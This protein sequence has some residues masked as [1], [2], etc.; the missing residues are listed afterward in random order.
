MKQYKISYILTTF[1]KLPYLKITLPWWVNNIQQG[2]QL[3]I[4][5]GNSTD[6]SIEFIKETIKNHSDILFISEK[7]CGE[8]H[9]LNKGILLSEGNYI[10]TISADDVYNL[11]AIRKATDWME[12]HNEI[13][14]MGSNGLSISLI[15]SNKIQFNPQ[16][17]EVYFNEYKK[18]HKPF[19]LSG[20]SYLIRKTSVSK[21]GL[22]NTHY[23]M[24]DFEYSL[25]G[26]SNPCIS[27][28]LCTT[29][30]Y[31]YIVTPSS[32]SI[33]MHRRMIEEHVKWNTFYFGSSIKIQLWKIKFLISQYIHQFYFHKKKN[34]NLSSMNYEEVFH[35]A[36]QYLQ[37]YNQKEL[38]ILT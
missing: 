30:F 17:Q 38:E 8:A 24:V 28:A 21:L 37:K 22:F 32:N 11:P 16:N 36:L 26:L 4:V 20:L 3:V 10:K 27:F 18:H 1:N 31:L 6:G 14:W 12:Q 7:D 35:E 29:P 15:H 34:N 25:R 2:E 9:G 23:K 19:M 33:T 13:D 5:D